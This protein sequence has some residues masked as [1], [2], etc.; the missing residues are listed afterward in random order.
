MIE[1]TK[2]TTDSGIVAISTVDSAVVPAGTVTAAPIVKGRFDEQLALLPD[3]IRV[4]VLKQMELMDQSTL[5]DVVETHGGGVS[6]LYKT[7]A[8]AKEANVRQD[9]IANAGGSTIVSKAKAKLGSEY[10]TG[11]GDKTD[12]FTI[13]KLV[14]FQ[15]TGLIVVMVVIIGLCLLSYLMAFLMKK[16]GLDGDSPK[17]GDV[18]VKPIAPQVKTS[19][20]MPAASC[21]L[22]PKAPSAHPGFNNAQLQAFL[23]MAAVAALD[24]HPG[25]TNDQLAV[26]FAIAAAEILGEPCAIVRFKNSN[27]SDWTSVVQNRVPSI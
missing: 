18:P 20:S 26:I 9:S 11:Q 14:E 24:I 22:D 27:S 16:F 4:P 17:K 1:Q 15:A 13:G 12:T 6:I 8:D 23:S 19:T 2:T 3:S 21:N 25:M 10:Y 5:F 7:Y